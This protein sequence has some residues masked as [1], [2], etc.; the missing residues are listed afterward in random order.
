MYA[1]YD[2]TLGGLTLRHCTQADYNSGGQPFALATSGSPTV[3][4]YY[5]KMAEPRAS[6]ASMDIGGVIGALSMSAGLNI[7]SGTITLPYRARAG[8]GTFA[9]GSSH[10]SIN[11]TDGFLYATSFAANQDDDG[12]SCNLDLIFKSSNGI[13]APVTFDVA[14]SVISTAETSVY[15]LGPASINGTAIAGVTGV[16]VN[17]GI[18][19]EAKRYNGS[20]YPQLIYIRAQRPSIDLQFESLEA[21]GNFGAAFTVMTAA[22]VYFR[23]RS[24]IGYV[25]DA[26]AEHVKFTFA[27][28]LITTE[29]ISGAG[30]NDGI[31]SAGGTVRLF[32]EAL[33]ASATSAIT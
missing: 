8:G 9:A 23:K 22:A 5:G 12:A 14:D 20:Q 30:G 19:I 6:F 26:T 21:I 16:T 11:G 32:G 2:A 27:D 31:Q 13:T 3:S 17:T 33:T 10:T 25:A 28:G 7:A 15:A 24:G 29:T 1:L 4:T 18:E